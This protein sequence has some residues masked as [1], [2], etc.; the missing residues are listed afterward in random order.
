[1]VSAPKSFRVTP[2]STLTHSF[3]LEER[4]TDA[5]SMD[6]LKG[7]FFDRILD[8]G[9]TAGIGANVLPPRLVRTYRTFGDYPVG[10]YYSIIH[11]ISTRMHPR[12]SNVEAM[13]RVSVRDFERLAESTVGRVMLSFAGDARATLLQAERMYGAILKGSA[14]VRGEAIEDGGIRLTYREFPGLAEYYPIGTIEGLCRHYRVDYEITVD[15]RSPR[16]AD[17]TIRFR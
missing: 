7:M 8:L 16:D 5:T 1:M 10:D 17:Y 14:K 11:E 13:R 9:K 15:V 12:V 2:T 4:I 3:V 6:T